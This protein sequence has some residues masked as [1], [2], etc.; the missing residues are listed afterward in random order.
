MSI[1]KMV[2]RFLCWKLPRDFGP[3]CGITFNRNIGGEERQYD[4]PFWPVGMNL[5]TA[6]QAEKMLTELICAGVELDFGMALEALKAGKKV[7]RAGWN[8][9]GMFLYFVPA[10]QYEPTTEIARS[11]FNGELVPYGAYLAMKTVQGNV[12]PWLASLTDVLAEDWLVL[13]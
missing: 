7:A 11:H 12:V 5:L 8:G 10:N 6:E 2:N 1:K 4:S 9:K 3:D 13:P